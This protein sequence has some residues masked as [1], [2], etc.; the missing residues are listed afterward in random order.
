MILFLLVA[1]AAGVASALLTAGVAAG[2]MV[3]VP[4]FYLAPLPVMIAGIAFSPAVA[5]IAALIAA[6]GL[7]W[8]YGGSFLLAYVVGMGVPAFGLSYAALLARAEPAGRD[9]LLWFPVGGLVLLAALF[10]TIGVTVAVL[11]LASD[12]DTYLTTIIN[13][14]D[15]LTA[16]RAHVPPEQDTVRMAELVAQVLPPMAAVASMVSLLACLYLAGRAALFSS[17]LSRPWPSLASLRLP[18]RTLPVVAVAAVLSLLPGMIGLLSSAALATLLLAY[19][20]AGFSVVHAITMGMGLRSI[21]LTG[22]WAATLM[23]GWPAIFMAGLGC[24]DAVLDLR[25][26]Y[27]RGR[28][29]PAANDR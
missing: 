16:T 28:Q 18:A 20:L 10:S 14:M 24:L 7:G 9:G 23:L 17:R 6:A 29:P 21:I 11:T 15:A 19:A 8:A 2:S 5:F 27:T 22:L 26:R 13:M 1:I 3:A 25:S 12:Y 4:L